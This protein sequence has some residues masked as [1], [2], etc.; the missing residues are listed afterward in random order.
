MPKQVLEDGKVRWTR[1]TYVIELSPDACKARKSPCGGDCGKTPVY[2]GQTAQTAEERF[3][4][5]KRGEKSSQW[6]KKYGEKLRP[7]LAG[8][9]GEMA[10][11][12]E[13]EAAEVELAEQLRA[14]S[15]YCVYGGH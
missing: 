10:T 9:Y 15:L 1:I 14:T 3:A 4:Q 5:H 13:S 6:V 2:V 8:S 11:V 12:S 7:D